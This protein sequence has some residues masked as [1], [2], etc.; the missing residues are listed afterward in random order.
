MGFNEYTDVPPPPAQ[1]Y[2]PLVK[3]L[4]W[5]CLPEFA[6]NTITD[7]TRP[8]PSVKTS[9]D[10]SNQQ[11]GN[12]PPVPEQGG[13]SSSMMQMPLIKFVN[14][15]S[16]PSFTKVNNIENARKPTT[17]YAKIYRSKSPSSSAMSRNTDAPII[18][19]W[20]SETESEIDYTVR[21]SI[22][23]TKSPSPRGNQRNWNNQKSQQL[24]K[25]FVMQNKAC[26]KCGCFDHLAANCGI[27]G[28]KGESWPRNNYKN[29]TPGVVL[30]KSGLKPTS[31]I[32]PVSTVRPTLNVDQSKRTSF[33]KTTHSSVKRPFVRKTAAQ[34]QAWVPKFPTGRTDVP[35][36]VPTGR[37]KGP[38]VGLK[39]PTAKLTTAANLGNKGKAVKASARWIWKPKQ[40][41]SKQ[42]SNTNGGNLH[43]NIDDK[44]FWDSGCSRHMTGNI[45]Y[46]SDFEPYDGGYQTIVATSTT[47]AEYVAAASC[48]GQVLWIQ[49]KLLD[50][51]TNHI[52]IRHHFIRDGYEKK[53]IN[54][55]HIHTDDNVADLLTKPF[56]VG[57]FRYLVGEEPVIPTELHHTP[58]PQQESQHDDDQHI[59]SPQ[60]E[61]IIPSS[62]TTQT[63]PQTSLPQTSQIPSP[64]PI[65]RRLTKSAIRIAQSKALSPGA[66][67]PA[68]LLR[69][70]R[71]GEAFLTVTSLDAGQDRENI[72]KTYA[73]PHDSPPRVTSFGDDEGSM[74]PTI[75]ELMEFCTNLQ[76]QANTMTTKIKDQDL[77]ITQLKARVKVLED[78]ERRRQGVDQEDAPNRGGEDTR[79]SGEEFVAEKEASK[80][81]D[82]GSESSEM[83]NILSSMGAANIL[84]SGGMKEVAPATQQVPTAS[85]LVA[86]ASATIAPVVATASKSLPTTVTPISRKTRASRGIVIKSS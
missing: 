4:S 40:N 68:S 5:T 11:E 1:V 8:S 63:P 72:I 86:T 9:N 20:E 69:D 54:V 42:G 78:N 79:V 50:Y 65:S 33:V 19:D 12:N 26:F 38:T 49:N 82:K 47:K 66:D 45:S 18:E 64:T 30:L 59:P 80:N 25:D 6:D 34:K 17:K 83:A 31:P 55:E 67:E 23:T 13:T 73:I 15:T 28:N 24:G 62:A 56:D 81:T 85:S 48:C 71:H 10:V 84:A 36:N 41:D 75:V 43:D 37:T 27:W 57:R 39:V 21:S 14:N 60:Q 2:S 22:K 35:T 7:Y 70:V 16:C 61:P 44:G 3:D 77:E 52:D 46:L 51:G 58:S 29:M 76:T 32:R 74:Q 53:L